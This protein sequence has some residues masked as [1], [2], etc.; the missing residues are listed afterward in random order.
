M[1]AI[2]FILGLGLTAT[3][4]AYDTTGNTTVYLDDEV[5]YRSQ[6]EFSHYLVSE[7]IL[8]QHYNGNGEHTVKVVYSGDDRYNPTTETCSFSLNAY[9]C[10]IEEDGSLFFELSSDVSGVLTVK[11]NGRTILTKDIEATYHRYYIGYSSETYRFALDDLD[12]GA[13]LIEVSFTSDRYSFDES[14]E[15]YNHA[16]NDKVSNQTDVNSISEDAVI[17]QTDGNSTFNREVRAGNDSKISIEKET[18]GNPL[19]VLAL[20]LSSAVLLPRRK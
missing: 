13:N 18:A 14:F 6:G 16:S 9:Y 15:Y 3:V 4:T 2:Q 7:E 20:A 12:S 19:F 10:N 8:W 17:N 1:V 11:A 5:I